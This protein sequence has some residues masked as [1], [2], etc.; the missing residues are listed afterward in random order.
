MNVAI[1]RN[2]R[3]T[4]VTNCPV[5]CPVA[6]PLTTMNNAPRGRSCAARGSNRDGTLPVF[7]DHFP[8]RA[9]AN[10]NWSGGRH[11]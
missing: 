9:E 10:T 11:E 5:G 3:L 1:A 7:R 6:V 8:T 2:T 4:T